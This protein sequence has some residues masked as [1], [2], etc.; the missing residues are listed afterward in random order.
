MNRSIPQLLLL[1]FTV[2]FAADRLQAAEFQVRTNRGEALKALCQ[3]LD[4]GPGS[5]VADVGCGEGP[6]TMIF[7]AVV[8]E[9]GTVLAEEIDADK[10]KKVVENADKRGFHQVVPILGQSDDPRLPDGLANVIY[11]NRVFHHFS[12]PQAMLERM[13][14]DLKPGGFLVIVDQQKGPLTDWAPLNSREKQHHWTGETTVVRLAR[15]AGFLFHDVLD[16]LWYEKQ[17]FVLVFR[18]PAEPKKPAGEPDLPRPLDV[19][20]LVHALPPAQNEGS[21]V[22]FFGL[23]RG[24]AVGPALREQLPDSTRF[25]DIIIDEWA[26]SREELPPETQHAG[27]EVLRTEKG[28]L[29]MPAGVHV[30]LVLFVDAYH[31]LWE[32]LPLLQRLKE[33]MPSSGLVAVV[34]RKGPDAEPRRLAAHRRRLSSQLVIEDLR[35][36]GF[37]LRQTLS[38]PA[39]DRYFLLFEVAASSV[40]RQ[41]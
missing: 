22:V 16:D 13:W 27:I 29:A 24:R 36:A 14:F 1:T 40:D 19:K 21:A 4:I 41:P 17:P 35:K 33:H 8:G 6:D 11:M 20:A 37:H 15:E 30:N 5:T 3:R 39:E 38:A 2:L 10:L 34:E 26:L 23:D 32:P 25:F 28:N 9:H 12:R 7:A 31:R 18:K